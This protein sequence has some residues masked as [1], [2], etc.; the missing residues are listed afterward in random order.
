[1]QCFVRSDLDDG[2]YGN[3]KLVDRYFYYK[4][5]GLSNL[6]IAF[7]S[8]YFLN[9]CSQNI[10]SSQKNSPKSRIGCLSALLAS[11]IIS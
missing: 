5:R 2:D 4:N 8:L 10:F 3:D 1:M 7:I 6:I 9:V 11:T